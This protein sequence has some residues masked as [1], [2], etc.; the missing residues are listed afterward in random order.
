M[1]IE[2]FLRW[3][4]QTPWSRPL[5]ES[6]YAWPL[7]ESTHVLTLALFL[8]TAV[9]NDLRLLGVGFTQIPVAE[10]TSRLLRITRLAFGVM[11]VTGLLLFYSN[12][13]HYYHN[14]FFRI[15]LVLLVISGANIALFHGRIHKRV[16]QWQEARRPP[17]AARL[18]GAISLATWAGIVIA[19]RLIAYNWFDCD[20]PPQPA[21]IVW[22]AG[23]PA[24]GAGE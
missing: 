23:C 24:S 11:V 14:L 7:L 15:K 17:R 18:A 19:G 12:P 6:L 20:K 3:L 16:A 4:E 21:V 5:L 22:L 13:V 8:G 9:V 1:G 2:G 10:V